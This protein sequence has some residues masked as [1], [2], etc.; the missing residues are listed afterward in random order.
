MPSPRVNVIIATYNWSTVLPYAISSVLQQTMDDF[1]LLVIGDGCTD[2][3]EQVVANFTDPRVRWINLPTNFGHQA[4]PNNRGLQEAKGEFV[5]YLGHDDLW[6]PHHLQ[7]MT[8]AL[9]ENDGG[10]AHSLL[11]RIDADGKSAT[12]V[13]PMPEHGIG[14]PPSCTVYRHS[15]TEK[16]GGWGDYRELTIA[17]EADLFRRAQAAGYRAIFVPRLTAIKFPASKR[18]DV[19][20]DRPCHEQAALLGQINSDPDFESRQL[21]RMIMAGDIVR[22]T[23]ARK[24]VRIL[25][26][27]LWKRLMWRL[28]PKS[29]M[30]ALF[31]PSK[32]AGIDHHKKYKGL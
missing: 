8:E 20:R 26:Q 3:T 23:A 21:V 27:E 1:E 19:Y 16:I 13:M 30:R 11:V 29:G 5:A 32:G 24:L 17:P 12:P 22:A 18:K 9:Q 6:L 4:G 25:A 15:V 7:C 28:G 2:D 31:W 14:G 10:I